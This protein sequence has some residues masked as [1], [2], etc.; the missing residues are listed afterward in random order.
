MTAM[1]RTLHHLRLP[2]LFLAIA[3]LLAALWA[4]LLRLGWQLPGGRSGLAAAH[5]PLMVSGFLGTL[6][7]LERAVA[8]GS[9]WSY[10]APLA[11]GGGAVL[12]LAGSS[13]IGPLL[14]T[15]GSLG[16]LLLFVVIVRRHPAPYTAVMGAG[17]LAWLAGN[18]LW[19]GGQP[20]HRA[21]YWW[22]GFLVLTIVGER[23]EL[24]RVL[25]PS[26]RTLALFGA[27]VALLLLG[28]LLSTFRYGAGVR[29][30]GTGL[31]GLALWLARYDVARRTIRRPGL[32]RYIAA[33]LLSGYAW[34]GIGG[35]LALYQG[36]VTAGPYY[37]A[38][39]HSLF[40]GFVFAMIFGHAP[41]ILPGLANIVLPFSRS[42]YAP[43]VLLHLSLLLRVVAD[44]VAWYPGR[45]WGG[46]FN[47]ITL[48]LFMALTANAVRAART[49]ETRSQPSRLPPNRQPTNQR[50][51]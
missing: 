31:L 20:V 4:G 11:A 36:G 41:I 27:G 29:M 13:N 37:D 51:L 48:L 9:T 6:I 3:A 35:A 2:L 8:L 17:A 34:L 16:L 45:R 38:I 21:A 49:P 24:S 28:L 32:T 43:L 47:V 1:H 5:G 22:V 26:G 7:S 39:L 15:L 14:L 25:R 10:L 42:L 30:T 40:L 12:L 23:L 50:K 44:L 19:L 46:M 33:C 18:I